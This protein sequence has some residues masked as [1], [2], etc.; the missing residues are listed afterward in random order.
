M[1][2]WLFLAVQQGCLRFVIE[3][4]PDHTHLL[5]LAQEPSDLVN[6]L[7]FKVSPVI[8]LGPIKTLYSF[9]KTT[10]LIQAE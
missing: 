2:E 4:F 3:V 5:F 6:E 10:Q 9:A 7:P 8:P 1:V